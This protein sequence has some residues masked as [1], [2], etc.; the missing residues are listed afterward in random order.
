MTDQQSYDAEHA[1][2]QRLQFIAGIWDVMQ[3]QHG[4][5]TCS[6]AMVKFDEGAIDHDAR[7]AA[8]WR[9]HVEFNF[10]RLPLDLQAAVKHV[11]HE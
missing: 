2:V 8:E 5:M 10:P 4:P 3:A 7:H 1:F 9:E 6:E 11:I